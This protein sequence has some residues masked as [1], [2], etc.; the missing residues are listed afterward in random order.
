MSISLFTKPYLIKLQILLCALAMS[1]LVLQTHSSDDFWIAS[2]TGIGLRWTAITALIVIAIGILGRVRH[3]PFTLSALATLVILL[4][5][6]GIF[7]SIS[8]PYGYGSSYQARIWN[9]RHWHVNSFGLRGSEP[10][11]GES[12]IIYLGDSYSAGQAISSESSVFNRIAHRDLMAC[13]PE[14]E[15]I[16]ISAPGMNT[17]MQAEYLPEIISATNCDVKCLVWQYLGNDILSDQQSKGQRAV[18]NQAPSKWWVALKSTSALVSFVAMHFPP[19]AGVGHIERYAPLYD[20][21]EIWRDHQQE[22][23]EIINSM[24][25][26]H[27][28]MVV[29]L[30]PFN[31]VEQSASHSIYLDKVA[32]FF[33][34][35]DVPVIGLDQVYTAIPIADQLASRYDGHPSERVHQAVGKLVGEW[36][37]DH[38]GKGCR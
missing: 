7:S 20:S 15:A 27:V 25:Q 12:A 29:V 31:G 38:L 17:H 19:C 6:E 33:K 16:H 2:Y 18:S 4:I 23:D 24:R 35:R 30:F 14:L 10:V 9:Y 21:E 28:P 11:K 8:L 34:S 5:L 3:Q 26:K 37:V 13:K 36:L 22:M 32:S 1:V